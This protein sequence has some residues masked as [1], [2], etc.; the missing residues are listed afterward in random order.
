MVEA[1][2]VVAWLPTAAVREAVA[3][4][5]P[6]AADLAP[7]APVASWDDLTAVL[8]AGCG[9]LVLGAA[10]LP[11]AGTLPVRLRDAGLD[12]AVILVGTGDDAWYA[13]ALDGGI[14]ECVAPDQPQR[15]VAVV[16]RELAR[17]AQQRAERAALTQSVQLLDHSATSLAV[18]D[19]SGQIV[20]VNAT[21]RALT[22]DASAAATC[23]G[24]NYLAVC[25]AASGPDVED[26]RRVAALL[27]QVLADER[28]TADFEYACHSPGEQRWFVGR[29]V[30]LPGPGPARALVAHHNVTSRRAAAEALERSERRYRELVENAGEAIYVIQDGQ[31]CFVNRAA[32][33]LFGLRPEEMLGRLA[34]D[35]VPPE[36][37][38]DSRT[39]QDQVLQ[40]LAQV[41]GGCQ[42]DTPAGRRWL[43]INAVRI[44]WEGR[45]AT[46]NCAADVTAERLASD[47]LRASE[48][49][50]QSLFD[51]GAIPVWEEDFGGVKRLVE[52]LR[53]AGVTD[54][55]RYLL[56][57]RDDLVACAAAVRVV[58]ANQASLDFFGV[59]S[60]DDLLVALPAYFTDQAWRCFAGE[61][62]ALASGATRY[63]G[64]FRIRDQF[65]VERLLALRLAVPPDCRET[66]ERVLVSWVDLT[67]RA[68]AEEAL[69]QSEERL[70]LLFDQAPLGMTWTALDLRLLR[71]NAEFCR[72]LG[73]S[74]MELSGCLVDALTH[75]DDRAL[76][77]QGVARLLRGEVELFQTDKRYLRSD[78]STVWGHL[79]VR[80]L[81]DLAGEPLALL[82]TIEDITERRRLTAQLQEAQRV[83]SLGRL[84]GGVAHDLNNLL[85]PILGYGQ[86]LQHDLPLDDPRQADLHDVVQAAESAR[87]LTRHLLA[88]GRRQVLD[89]Q[90]LDLAQLVR[91]FRPLLRRALREDV[92]LELDLP[93]GLPAVLAD[94]RQMEQVLMNLLLNAQDALPEGGWIR[95]TG[96]VLA[97]PATA[98]SEVELTVAD[99]GVGMDPSTLARVF[100]PFFTTKPPGHGTG[101]GLA[102]CHGIVT[103][104]G[105]QIRVD[106]AP[107]AGTRVMVQLPTTAVALP[108]SEPAPPVDRPEPLRLRVLVVDDDAAVVRL[109]ARALRQAGHE[110]RTALGSGPALEL[111]QDRGVPVDLLFTD[112]VMPGLSGRQLYEQAREHR[113]A[114]RVLF[115]SAHSDEVV[116]H[117]GV[118]QER[119]QFIAKPFDVPTMLRAIAA[120]VAF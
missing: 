103:Q 104:H 14:A 25:E 84:A 62:A 12:Q 19:E 54:F 66:W 43:R 5:W 47:A 15:L 1:A 105:G 53:A 97:P 8:R 20:W 27:R 36:L 99:N 37:R 77:H 22:P 23:E 111:L 2:Q 93:P 4:A 94:G 13:A 72:F 50:W 102:T 57:H 64:E 87:D 35:F 10:D 79:R 18:V 30:R 106:S 73:R 92:Q 33:D 118:A 61:V 71:V 69:Q 65:G 45:P 38:S 58:S 114:L 63:E 82:S 83:E 78:D 74:A 26:A 98:A 81:R 7:L 109:T 100:E 17:S 80:L 108:A 28:P 46:L 52:Q 85:T 107:G 59:G 41:S 21:W 40:A 112:V 29:I 113:P 9:D 89:L 90:P 3:A 6:A 110:V 75:P 95:I 48:A 101:L 44:E 116:A 34:T 39:W 49:R 70:R 51:D 67:A 42:V 115:M 11:E 32:A 24:A 86:L 96:R 56:H 120:A 76:H 91:H 16:R 88:F 117:R 119:L 68:A 31:L 60:R 55:E